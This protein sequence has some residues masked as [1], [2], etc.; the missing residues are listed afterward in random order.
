MTSQTRADHSTTLLDAV[1]Q[2][3]RQ[4]KTE[5]AVE[6]LLQLQPQYPK[7]LQCYQLMFPLLFKSGRLTELQQ[8]AAIAIEQLPNQ[9]LGYQA[10]SMALRF[11]QQHQQAMEAL[12][13]AQRQ[14]GTSA[15]L[16]HQL[17]VLHKEAGKLELASDY[18]LQAINLKPTQADSWWQRA[19]LVS[20]YRTTAA[21]GGTCSVSDKAA[22]QGQFLLQ[23]VQCL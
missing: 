9:L 15:P 5:Q 18:L 19:D 8:Y 22:G 12:L 16:L 1:Q 20:Q 7:L 23:P 10:L 13:E 21:T 14:C 3:L 17:G 6:L 2:K 4:Q 11:T